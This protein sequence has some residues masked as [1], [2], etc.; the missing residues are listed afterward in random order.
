LKNVFR[1]DIFQQAMAAGWSKNVASEIG[2]DAGLVL[3]L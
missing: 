1:R 2:T 3:A